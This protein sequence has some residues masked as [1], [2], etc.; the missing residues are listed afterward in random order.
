MLLYDYSY[1]LFQNCITQHTTLYLY[2][3]HGL[4]ILYHLKLCSEKLTDGFGSFII[5]KK[6]KGLNF[7]Q[8][9][10]IN[11]KHENKI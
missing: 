1:G 11:I 10:L 4:L 7:K 2:I 3:Y 6:Q 8:Y 5:K 9:L